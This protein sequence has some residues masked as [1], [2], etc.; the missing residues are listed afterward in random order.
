MEVCHDDLQVI[1]KKYDVCILGASNVGKS[2]MIYRFIHDQFMENIEEEDLYTKKYI[3]GQGDCDILTIYDSDFTNDMYMKSMQLTILNASCLIFAYAIDDSN[4]FLSIED[5]YH[6]INMFRT[7]MPPIFIVGCKSDLEGERQVHYEEGGEL[8]TKLRAIS[9]HECS[10]KENVGITE[11]FKAVTDVIGEIRLKSQIS[12]PQNRLSSNKRGLT[13]VAYCTNHDLSR[14]SSMS[15]GNS[16]SLHAM[17]TDSSLQIPPRSPSQSKPGYSSNSIKVAKNKSLV[18]DS[19]NKSLV[20]D[21]QLSQIPQEQNSHHGGTST[22]QTTLADGE[23]TLAQ[24]NNE[25]VNVPSGKN[26]NTRK[27]RG[28]NRQY[29]SKREVESPKDKCCVIT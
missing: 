7:Q 10:A 2:S 3:N 21:T 20:L 26:D 29:S 16:N 4:S 17:R 6:H 22:S 23:T 15:L 27:R 5:Y 24:T 19:N 14:S 12:L 13:G 11:I 18:G 28:S 25:E 1:T 9:F 8:A